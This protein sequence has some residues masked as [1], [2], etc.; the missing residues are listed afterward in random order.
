VRERGKEKE[1]E[2]ERE[3]EGIRQKVKKVIFSFSQFLVQSA[4]TRP[5]R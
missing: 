2:K 3:I 4:S 1:K 5:E